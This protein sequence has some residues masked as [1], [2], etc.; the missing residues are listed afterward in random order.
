MLTTLLR[1]RMGTPQSYIQPQPPQQPGQI[2]SSGPNHPPGLAEREKQLRLGIVLLGGGSLGSGLQ[3]G[4]RY[5]RPRARCFSCLGCT[6]YFLQLN[7]VDVAEFI[8]T[9]KTF[10]HEPHWKFANKM[11]ANNELYP[12]SIPAPPPSD[13]WRQV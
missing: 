4:N 1:G 6:I 9:F 12:R 10:Y 7:H 2:P 8:A 3:D 13:V 11:Q 5:R